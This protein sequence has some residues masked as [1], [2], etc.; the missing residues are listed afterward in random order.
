MY[1]DKGNGIPAKITEINPHIQ[2]LYAKV[3][4]RQTECNEITKK[5]S[6]VVSQGKTLED[7][8]NVIYIRESGGQTDRQRERYRETDRDRQT[9][10]QTD[11]QT[12]RQ[13]YTRVHSY[14]YSDREADRQ[15]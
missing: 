7:L 1:W 4:C 14:K 13:T 2:Q 10:R 3:S 9:D 15:T 6:N 5:S 12:D 11:S 8:N